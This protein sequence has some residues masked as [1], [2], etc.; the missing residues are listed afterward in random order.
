MNDAFT[1]TVLVA[2]DPDQPPSH[3]SSH[4][5]APAAFSQLGSVLRE[6]GTG[7]LA[8]P[9]PEDWSDHRQAFDLVDAHGD[10]VGTA[11]IERD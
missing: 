5:S 2:G 6:A 7:D 9:N 4:P 3:E 1:L 10:Q 11:V 8:V